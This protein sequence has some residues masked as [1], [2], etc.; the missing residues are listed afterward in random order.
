MVIQHLYF[1]TNVLIA[2]RHCV[3]LN[4]YTQVYFALQKG[5]LL[6][7]IVQLLFSFLC[8]LATRLQP[9][10]LAIPTNTAIECQGYVHIMLKLYCRPQ[11]S[12]EGCKTS[13]TSTSTVCKCNHLTHFA[14]LLSA[15]PL[16]L[17]KEQTLSLQITGYIG[18]SISLVAM[19][20]T[21]FVFA[22]LK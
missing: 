5:C 12:T 18:V 17:S 13:F 22:F 7:G 19:A 16:N 15:R 14:I 3:V 2:T 10:L 20:V 8:T 9:R 21:I 11:W 4:I 6:A 1:C